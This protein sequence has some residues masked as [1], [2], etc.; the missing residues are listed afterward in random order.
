MSDPEF[1]VG[2]CPCCGVGQVAIMKTQNDELV[3]VC[4]ECLTG[5]RHPNDA[6]LCDN[7]MIDENLPKLAVADKERIKEAG[8]WAMVVDPGWY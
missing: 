2:D 5:W 8:W 4:N 7:A 1:H 3:C 6:S